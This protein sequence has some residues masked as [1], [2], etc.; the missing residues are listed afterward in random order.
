MA[1]SLTRGRGEIRVDVEE[2]RAGDVSG[3][4]ELAAAAG[5]A[6]LPAT[7]DELV[8]QTYQLPPGDAGS[9]TDAGWIT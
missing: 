4:V 7:V 2:A 9:G 6:E 3:E 1:A 5:L 8:A